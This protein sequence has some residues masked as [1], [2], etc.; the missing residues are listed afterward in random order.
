MKKRD[1]LP[2]GFLSFIITAVVIYLSLASNPLDL[3]SYTF[4]PGFDKVAH[5]LM[6]FGCVVVYLFDYTKYKSPHHTK[7]NVELVISAYAAVM[8]MF[9]EIAQL[10]LT[11]C[12]EFEF[13]DCLANAVG[14]VLGF[15][16]MRFWGIRFVRHHVLHLRH[17]H[18]HHSHVD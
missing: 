5:A 14:A 16:V 9:L 3:N 4:F 13:T 1:F 11:T 2:T 18:H 12:R 17:S 6:Y 15:L 7:L 8:G 10:G